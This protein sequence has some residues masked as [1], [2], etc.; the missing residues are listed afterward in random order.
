MIFPSPLT[1]GRLLRRYN[2]FLVDVEL[3]DG[4]RVTAHCANP[5]SMLGLIEIGARVFVSPSQSPNRKLLWT[6]ELMETANGYGGHEIIGVHTSHPNILAKEAIA[7]GRISHL[8][9]Y[10]SLRREVPYGKGSRIDIYLEHPQKPACYVEVKYAHLMRTPGRVEFPDSVTVRGQKHLHE[11]SLMK[12]L[13][14]RAVMLFVIP[15][16]ASSFS[17]AADIDPSYAN[18][19]EHAHEQGVESYAITCHVSQEGIDADHLIPIIR[20]T[21]PQQNTG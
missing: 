16:R 9:G 7:N 1:E 4:Q 21:N 18:A 11:L 15:R 6:L 20:D 12:Q 5:G 14:H 3:M 19:F 17:I 13:G 2:R 10:T 8:M